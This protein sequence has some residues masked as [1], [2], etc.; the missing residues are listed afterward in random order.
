MVADT[1]MDEI[2]HELEH[3]KEL[4][5]EADLLGAL[6]SVRWVEKTLEKIIGW[7]DKDD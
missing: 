6:S 1:L 4:I 3:T 5:W 7:D 2:M